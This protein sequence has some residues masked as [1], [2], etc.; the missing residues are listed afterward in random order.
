MCAWGY[1]SKGNHL[2]N[3]GSVLRDTSQALLINNKSPKGY[4]RASAALVALER[5][6]EALDVCDRCLAFDPNNSSVRGQRD[7]VAGLKEA[8]D[9]KEAEKA[10]RIRKEAQE[11]RVMNAAFQVS[12]G[13]LIGCCQSYSYP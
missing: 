3:Y 6:E 5:F 10:E 9:R 7:K 1:Y 13:A 8:W 11:K 2:G 12:L 4:F